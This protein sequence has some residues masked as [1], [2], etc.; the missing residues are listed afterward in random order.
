MT[1]PFN[2]L[3]SCLVSASAGSGKTYQLSQRFLYLVGAGADPKKVLTITFTQKAAMEMRVRILSRAAQLLHS[4][5]EQK[6]FERLLAS[7]AEHNSEP[8]DSKSFLTAQETAQSILEQSQSLKITTIDSIFYSW[9]RRFPWYVAEN[10]EYFDLRSAAQLMDLGQLAWWQFSQEHLTLE[11][12]KPLV[13]AGYLPAE[14]IENQCKNLERFQSL[15]WLGEKQVQGS[16]GFLPLSYQDDFDEIAWQESVTPLLKELFRAFPKYLDPHLIQQPSLVAMLQAGILSASSMKLHGNRFKGKKAEELAS[17]IDSLNEL[18]CLR[19]NTERKRKLN[20]Q[21][22]S[23]LEYYF[24]YRSLYD[25]LK[26]RGHR[27]EFADLGQ[28]V[29]NLFHD[30]NAESVR[31]LVQSGI[32]HLL[33][34]EFQDTSMLQWQIF[35]KIAWELLAG[36][37]RPGLLRPSVFLVGDV[38]Q[39]IYGFREA[40]PLVMN[41]AREAMKPMGVKGLDL[42]CSYRSSPGILNFVNHCFLECKLRDYLVHE[43]ARQEDGTLLTPAFSAIMHLPMSL[44]DEDPLRERLRKEAAALSEFVAH[45]LAHPREFPI[46]VSGGKYRPIQAADICILYRKTSYAPF[47]EESLRARQIPARREEDE[48]FFELPEIK[49]AW[50][51]L[52]TALNPEDVVAL[53]TILRSPWLGCDNDRIA[54]VLSQCLEYGPQPRAKL[55]MA[56]LAKTYPAQH[57]WLGSAFAA[58][59]VC[60]GLWRL[61]FK[62]EFSSSY[63]KRWS[64]HRSQQALANIQKLYELLAQQSL[65]A[66]F[67]DPC[68]WLEFLEAAAKE[69]STA[70]ARTTGQA[71]SLMTIHKAKG[72]EFPL[73]ILVQS[74]SE[75]F[76]EESQW[77]KRNQNGRLQ[78][79]FIGNKSDFPKEDPEFDEIMANSRAELEQEAYRLLYVA[80]TR[81]SQYILGI[82]LAGG[83]S[84][85]NSLEVGKLFAS[86]LESQAGDN[87]QQISLA[88][89]V[90]DVF[91]S[92][93]AP[94]LAG[95]GDQGLAVS[96]ALEAP[97]P[98]IPSALSRDNERLKGIQTPGLRILS[99]TDALNTLSWK[100]LGILDY[101]VSS[102]VIFSLDTPPMG[103][104]SLAEIASSLQGTLVHKAIECQCKKMDPDLMALELKMLLRNRNMDA[105][106]QAAAIQAAVRSSHQLYDSPYFRE[107]L[108]QEGMHFYLEK[109]VAG[110]IGDCLIRGKIDLFLHHDQTHSGHILDFKTGQTQLGELPPK[111]HLLQMALYAKLIQRSNLNIN[112]IHTSLLY[113]DSGIAKHVTFQFC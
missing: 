28:G 34:D 49:D 29:W 7:F 99:V 55:L 42:S 81:A 112:A 38:K 75:W 25:R 13:R 50:A 5:S 111:D 12:L 53:A 52:K 85:R 22:Y 78:L 43:A 92:G 30:E 9:L 44:S 10:S 89:G 15:L 108:D 103:V 63:S 3:H 58:D 47:F 93:P 2:P 80:L 67:R 73:V 32:E 31:Y 46:A 1:A 113:V 21:G 4:Q 59:T 109:G 106:S 87:R 62:S 79:S 74:D 27:I 105:D 19:H 91:P 8:I 95:W 72:L 35:S 18:T 20:I 84:Q 100:D 45:V 65:A 68:Q 90:V 82:S 48:G 69:D 33:I 14:S 23:Y 101:Q 104:S 86:Y 71:I 107:L 60:A 96:T 11:R 110:I 37:P 88:S 76:K 70:P 39:S 16:L 61:L 56:F 98:V 36:N 41:F 57:E 54:Q 94:D 83:K 66:D 17:T 102:K 24:S 77:T 64:P 26:I 51:M 40:E 97:A 6:N